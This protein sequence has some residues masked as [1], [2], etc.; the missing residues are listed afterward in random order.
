MS[1]VIEVRNLEK[2]FNEHP[3]LQDIHLN[4]LEGECYGIIGPK[5]AGKSSIMR[6][7]YCN[8]SMSSGE[9]FVL[10]LNVKT[11][12]RKIKA[13]IG[14]LPQQCGL[15]EE[16]SVLDNLLIYS[17]YFNINSSR[18]RTRAR[19]L[20]RFVHLEEQEEVQ[21]RCLDRGMQRRLALARSLVGQ[22]K[23]LFLDEPAAHL[24]TQNRRW[25]WETL[26][27]LKKQGITLVI[28]TSYL[29]EAQ[30]LCDRVLL[31]DRGHILSEG[32]PLELIDKYI[33]TEVIEF[34]LDA[35][36]MEYYL[37]RIRDQ[38]EYQLINNR[39]RLFIKP[40]QDSRKAF[41][42]IDSEGVLARKSSLEDVF[43]IL[44]GHELE[45][46]T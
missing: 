17:N 20:L 37:K 19:E 46:E 21:V 39:L 36:D 30:K 5:G 7:M 12:A 3:A 42:I 15:D 10:G 27:T 22:P 1:V 4:I 28:T 45:K 33:G 8:T 35:E 23:I 18:A 16:F 25:I 44:A 38:F 2:K 11:N 13:Q 29:E 32:S 34:Q 9:L 6:I 40:G 24:D 31:I 41:G 43:L 14:V 26:A